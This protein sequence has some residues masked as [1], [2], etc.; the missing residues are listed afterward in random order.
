MQIYTDSPEVRAI[1]H[2]A[3][4]DYNGRT[5]RVCDFTGPMRL[6]SNWEGGSRSYYCVLDLASL[7]SIGIAENGTPFSNGGQIERISELPVNGAVVEHCIFCG[8]D[9]GIRIYVNPENLARML[10]PPV[11]LTRDQKIVLVATRGLKSFARFDEAHSYTGISRNDYD[12]AKAELIAKGL[13]KPNGSITDQGRNAAGD[14]RLHDLVEKPA[15]A[16]A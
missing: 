7:R 2:A 5:F 16:T 6:D 12:Q 11:E 4:P 14:T 13:L 3:F 15:M 10:P 8:K 9:L 1:A